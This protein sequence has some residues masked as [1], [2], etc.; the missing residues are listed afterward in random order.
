MIT[1][2]QN[3]NASVNLNNFNITRDIMNESLFR[4]TIR[5][6]FD[7]YIKNEIENYSL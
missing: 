5:F 7:D 4:K 2:S 3:E 1:E 6:T